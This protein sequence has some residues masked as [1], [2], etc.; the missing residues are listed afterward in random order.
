MTLSQYEL[1]LRNDLANL[2]D[3]EQY[4]ITFVTFIFLN[5]KL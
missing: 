4:T 2:P 5:P 3:G 1:A